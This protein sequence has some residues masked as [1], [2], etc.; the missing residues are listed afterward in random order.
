MVGAIGVNEIKYLDRN[1]PAFAEDA[2]RRFARDLF[3]L[4]GDFEPLV[5]ERDQ[6][7]RLRAE[8]GDA[9]VLKIANA[10]ED[11]GVIDFQ[12]RALMHV[13]RQDPGMPVPRV[14]RAVNGA[15]TRTVSGPGGTRHV[16]HVLTYLPGIVGEEAPQCP[17]LWRTMGALMARLDL[18]L[19]G[20]FHP[21]A[22]NPHPWDVMRCP[23]LRAHTVHIADAMARGNVEAVLDLMAAVVIPKLRGLRHQVI[24]QDANRA[25]V[26]VDAG[27]PD[28]ASGVLDFGDMVHGPLIAEVA[29]TADLVGVDTD[30]PVGVLCDVAAG[31]D[32]VLP[33]E[34]DEIDLIYD[35]ALSRIA[36]ALTIIAWRKAATPDQPAYLRD[37]EEPGW[38]LIARMME[39]S[40]EDVCNRLRRACRFPPYCP[41]DAP[42]AAPGDS[43]DMIARRHRVLGR[44]LYLFYDKPLHFERGRGPWLYTPRGEAYLDAYNNVP[45]VGHCHP[46][47]VNAVSRQLAALNTNTRYLYDSILEYAERLG[48]TMPGELGACL[49]VNSGSEANDVALHMA[50]LISGRR[51]ALIMAQA[52]HGITETIFDL[53]PSGDP[54][55]RQ[56]EQVRTLLVPDPYRGPYRHGEPD[57]VE[58]YAADAERAI[59][60]LEEAGYGTAAFIF[61]S[62]MLSSGVPDVP[63]GYLDSVA[64]KTRAAG[65]LVIADEVQSGFARSGTHMWG[66]AAN[67]VVPDIVTL[68]KPVGNGFPLGVVVTRPELL[69][70]FGNAIGLFSTFGGNP[71]ACA[72]GLA[73]LDVIEDEGLLDNARRMGERLRDGLGGLTDRHRWIGDVR[74]RGL[75]IGVDLVGDRE[76]RE[77]AGAETK[78]LLNLARDNGALIGLEG[79]H[80]NV[81]KLRPPLIY[82][83]EHCD[84]LLDILDRSFAQL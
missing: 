63:P 54:R 52:Y 12:T 18:A 17:R 77:P 72:A 3:G 64:A 57:L 65:G 59:A 43:G 27:R 38:A 61:D 83:E 14:V 30:D 13:E 16:V 20:F 48:A 10:E 80:N 58:R 35:L 73:V 7:F 49:F 51:G 26:L 37:L 74:G 56:P 50:R 68:G 70:Q 55:D 47:V 66:F 22:D 2:V 71:V 1:P 79:E 39:E 36:T 53:S 28:T 15:V 33:L 6:N 75:A 32:S 19:R 76:T 69:D 34:E 24:H 31:F 60:E 9:F 21:S 81:V 62:F 67:Q 41:L 8:D 44:N 46:H 11:P 5:S 25:N 40:R 42:S 78:R 82:R 84:R 45:V 29:L 4:D 23:D